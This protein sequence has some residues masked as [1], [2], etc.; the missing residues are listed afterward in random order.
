MQESKSCAL[1]LGD[2]PINDHI[3][4]SYLRGYVNTFFPKVAFFAL[5]QQDAR[6]GRPYFIR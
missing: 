3:I 6:A 4:L 5:E 1:P 2:I